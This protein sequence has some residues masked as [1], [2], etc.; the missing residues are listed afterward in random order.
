MN[1]EAITGNSDI[2]VR[3]VP[4]ACILTTY[5]THVPSHSS[6]IIT[7]R[8]IVAAFIVFLSSVYRFF[9]IRPSPRS[10]SSL[11]SFPRSPPSLSSFPALPFKFYPGFPFFASISSSPP[12]AGS[13]SPFSSFPSICPDNAKLIIIL[14]ISKTPSALSFATASPPPANLPCATLSS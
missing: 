13:S 10:P 3:G 1:A 12:S 7:N 14:C 9:H 8:T 4:A 6:P 5:H 2:S 11:G